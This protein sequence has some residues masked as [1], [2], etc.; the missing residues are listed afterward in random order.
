M[1]MECPEKQNPVPP[2]EVS[3]NG[4]MARFVLYPIEENDMFVMYKKALASFWV[5]EE[6][7]LRQD[8]DDFETKLSDDERHFITTVLSFFA[9]SDGIVNEN[10]AINMY[11]EVPWPE[12]KC[13]YG[14]Q[15]AVENIHSE[16]YSLLI[17][18]YIRDKTE[19]HN[20]L[21][22]AVTSPSVAKKAAW[23]LRWC[24]DTST[25][26]A[27]RLVAF[28]C[29]EGI[30]FS[31]S[32]CAIFW[33]KKRGLLPG[34]CFSNELI[35][36]DEGLHC[37]FACLLHRKMRASTPLLTEDIVVGIV[38]DA[39]EVEMHFVE[40]ALKVAVIGMNAPAMCQY[41][42]FCANHLLQSLGYRKAYVDNAENP[43]EWMHMIS[44]QGKTNFF[45]KRVGEYA[46]CGVGSVQ[47]SRTPDLC[48]AIDDMDF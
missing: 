47:H 18:T 34:L 17:D 14:L 45:E 27:Q 46:R 23:A 41:V 30:F 25:S 11:G 10:L 2:T 39:V 26:F 38:R 40:D 33:L 12:A 28:A 32:F 36:R 13:F 9:A 20:L 42:R 29:V 4:D 44:L 24:N 7:D 43:F 1:N 8:R 22:A 6:V 16:V 35:S 31:S 19:K 5:P 15:I 37:E 48:A 21:N 3:M